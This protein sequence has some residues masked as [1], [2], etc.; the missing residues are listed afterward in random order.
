MNTVPDASLRASHLIV[1]DFMPR[2]VAAAMR[3]AIE[4]YLGNPYSHTA[5][6]RMAWNY[7][8]V[9][10]LYAYLRA[11]PE[12]VLG[13]E[14]AKA[15]QH[16]LASWSTANYGLVPRAAPYLGLYVHGC[17][18]NEHNDAAN[19]RFGFVYSLTKNERRTIGGETLIWREDA[20]APRSMRQPKF[21]DDLRHAISPRFNR[22]LLFDDHMPHAVQIV[23]GD[24]DPLEGRVVLHGH[25]IERT[26]F[27][28]GPAPLEPVMD[29]AK[30]M[31]AQFFSEIKAS[32]YHGLVVVRITFSPEGKVADCRLL[33][34]RVK[35]LCGGDS[36]VQSVVGDL[37]GRAASLRFPPSEEASAVTIPVQFG[38]QPGYAFASRS[39]SGA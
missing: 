39:G 37:L 19:G 20:L 10:G 26:P 29:V 2:E 6:S 7:F 1:D 33:V 14:L 13:A 15:F 12:R 38:D 32:A 11:S 24:M 5:E 27:I 31:V 8:Y 34:D 17:R 16:R 36:T 4:E 35:Q 22:L 30:S 25:L 9:P 21:G 3:A 18:Q 23:E 28:D